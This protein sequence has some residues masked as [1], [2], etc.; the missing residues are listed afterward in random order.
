M[1]TLEIYKALKQ[2][3]NED[4]T[5]AKENGSMSICDTKRGV[6]NVN[7]KYGLFQAYNNKGEQLTGLMS[8]NRFE[9]WLVDQYV[10]EL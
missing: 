8:Q 10:V 5:I 9:N 4:T 2:Y 3:A 1:T 7:Y 6:I